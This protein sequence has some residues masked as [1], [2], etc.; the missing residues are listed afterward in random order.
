MKVSVATIFNA[1]AD[2]IWS[3]VCKSRLLDFVA[4]PLL[5]FKPNNG[6]SLP[7]IW[8][9]ADHRVTMMAF[10]LLPIGWQ[11]ISTSYPASPT[12]GS[13]QLRDNGRG[14]SVKRWDHLITVTARDDGRTDYRDDVI[15]EAGLLTPLV[16]AYAHFFYRHRQKR[17]RKLIDAGFNYDKAGGKEARA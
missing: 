10:G 14:A 15:V 5:V 9:E 17:W 1:S 8:N 16:F 6:Q 3:E 2:Q 4:A 12:A 7:D 11:I 13:R